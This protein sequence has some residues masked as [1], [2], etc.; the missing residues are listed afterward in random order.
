MGSNYNTPLVASG[1]DGSE[2]SLKM[3]SSGYSSN[4]ERQQVK[5]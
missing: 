2:L 4:K 1:M 3:L 5:N